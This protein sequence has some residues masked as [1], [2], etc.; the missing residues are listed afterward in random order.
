MTIISQ[1]VMSHSF[2][3]R[4]QRL[5]NLSARPVLSTQRNPVI[6]TKSTSILGFKFS[7][8]LD[9]VS[10]NFK[11]LKREKNVKGKTTKS[12]DTYVMTKQAEAEGPP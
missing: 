6:K 10:Y 9:P 8:T 12:G 11:E 1:V 5:V 2:N 3:S 7:F 4:R